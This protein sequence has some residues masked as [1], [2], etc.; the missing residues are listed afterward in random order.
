VSVYGFLAALVLAIHAAFIAWVIFGWLVARK[1]RAWRWLH[2][3]SVIYGMVI[4]LAPWPCPL[5]LLEQ[6]LEGQAGMNP[7]QQP[8]L[9]HYLEALVYPDIPVWLLIGC[10]MLVCGINLYLHARRIL[11]RG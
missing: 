11:G 8:F 1:R 5:T 7:Y 4:E 6:W 10:A 9:I 3:G 2:L